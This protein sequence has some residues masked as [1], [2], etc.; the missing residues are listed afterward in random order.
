MTAAAAAATSSSSFSTPQPTTPNF[1]DDASST[2]SSSSPS[3]PPSLPPTWE[4]RLEENHDIEF[5]IGVDEAGRGPLAGPVVAAACYI[6]CNVFIPG[7]QD[8]KKMDEEAREEAFEA[9]ME[10]GREGGLGVRWAVEVVGEGRIDEV[11]ILQATL[12]GMGAALRRVVEGGR[13]GGWEAGSEAGSGG[14]GGGEGGKGGR[15]GGSEAGSGGGGGDG[16]VLKNCY[17]LI[18][19]NQVPKGLPAGLEGGREG[20]GAARVECVVK[21]DSKVRC[22]AAAS[23]LA[24]VTRDRIM[25]SEGREGGREGRT[26]FYFYL[27]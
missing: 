5:V 22:I 25:V 11:N 12:Q 15:A 7:L 20:G 6:P 27:Y 18:D 2:I 1:D 4:I 23:I 9:L 14:G 16:K 17:A 3:I 10:G 19:G 24:K 8:S 13:E 21:G 26:W